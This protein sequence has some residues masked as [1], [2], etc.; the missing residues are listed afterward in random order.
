[1]PKESS[2]TEGLIKL[3]TGSFI[4]L[5]ATGFLCAQETK[6]Q[7]SADVSKPI[8]QL[9]E[10]NRKLERQNQELMQQNRELMEKINALGPS[11]AKQDGTAQPAPAQSDPKP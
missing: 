1:M 4:L 3:F 11:V 8:D 9:I 7:S 2:Q 6:D 5:A 10:Q